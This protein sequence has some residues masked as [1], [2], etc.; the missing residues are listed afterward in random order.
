MIIYDVPSALRLLFK[1]ITVAPFL[2][3]SPTLCIIPQ[4]SSAT[5]I[6]PASQ[7]LPVTCFPFIFLP[8]YFAP[9]KHIFKKVIFQFFHFAYSQQN[10][11]EVT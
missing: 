7:N 5:C 2:L 11:A 6:F 3:P 4:P 8:L 9:Q 10:S 1:F